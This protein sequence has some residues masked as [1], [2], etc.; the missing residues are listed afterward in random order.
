MF[1]YLLLENNFH[2]LWILIN[3]LKIVAHSNVLER[4][5]ILGKKINYGEKKM[6]H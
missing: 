5:N 4:E 6:R 1:E 3:I 2:N